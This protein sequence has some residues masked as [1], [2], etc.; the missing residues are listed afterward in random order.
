MGAPTGLC[1]PRDPSK[2]LRLPPTPNTPPPVSTCRN[3]S[4]LNIPF[5]PLDAVDKEIIETVTNMTSVVLAKGATRNLLKL[6]N[7]HPGRFKRKFVWL[8]MLRC[9]EQWNY[10]LAVRRFLFEFFGP[11]G[12]I[13]AI[14]RV[15][16]LGIESEEAEDSESEAEVERK[17]V[18]NAGKFNV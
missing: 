1:I 2:F 13:K 15:E 4:D 8:G 9:F 10:P 14:G 12:M 11:R 17:P 6:K 7:Q 18:E 16:G 3:L 5:P